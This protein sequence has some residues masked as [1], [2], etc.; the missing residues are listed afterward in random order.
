MLQWTSLVTNIF[1]IFRIISLDLILKNGIN[2]GR[3]RLIPKKHLTLLP[4]SHLKNRWLGIAQE[5]QRL[6]QILVPMWPW[7]CH[8]SFLSFNIFTYKMWVRWFNTL[9][10]EH[11]LQH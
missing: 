3:T 6:G 8:S 9:D 10:P 4:S 7:A 1:L 11:S 5:P 2:G